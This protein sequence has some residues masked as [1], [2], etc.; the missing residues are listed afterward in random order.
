MPPAYFLFWASSVR[1]VA[2]TVFQFFFH[3]CLKKKVITVPGHFFDVRPY[4][5]RPTKEPYSHLVRFSYGPNRRTVATALS[6][7]AEVIREHR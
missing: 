3:E 7:M 6:R 2:S 1:F 4:R 5:N